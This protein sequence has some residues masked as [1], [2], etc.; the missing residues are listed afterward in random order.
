[1]SEAYKLAEY[2]IAI[3]TVGLCIT[4]VWLLFNNFLKHT[5]RQTE[6]FSKS[7]SD[8]ADR[9]ERERNDWLSSEERRAN[10]TNEVLSDLKEIIKDSL[11]KD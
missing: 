3:F 2:G 11:R 5:E 8:L 10:Q 9:H 6:T 7:V 1:M 4:V